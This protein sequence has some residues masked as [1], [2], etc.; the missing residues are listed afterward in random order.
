MIMLLV[1][2]PLWGWGVINAPRP[3]LAW[4]GA[5][6]LWGWLAHQLVVWWN[7]RKAK[8][9]PGLPVRDAVYAELGRLRM[10]ERFRENVRSYLLIFIAGEMLLFVGLTSDLRES[11]YAILPFSAVVLA[12]A[13]LG[14]RGNRRELERVVRP[15]R[16]ELESWVVGLEELEKDSG[17]LTQEES[18]DS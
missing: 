9:D 5:I 11:L 2:I 4:P 6:L 16:A 1:T 15:L 7:I 8:P 18:H 13:A 14:H 10:L 17:G 12:L 3:L